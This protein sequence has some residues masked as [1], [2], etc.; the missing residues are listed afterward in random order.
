[1]STAG[2]ILRCQEFY[3][4]AETEGSVRITCTRSLDLSV[5]SFVQVTSQD[6]SAVGMKSI[7]L[8]MPMY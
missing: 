8:I 7:V 3:E 4:V 1:M 6:G 5:Q 2:T